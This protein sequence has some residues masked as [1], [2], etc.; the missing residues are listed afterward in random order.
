MGP[1]CRIELEDFSQIFVSY[2]FTSF[3]GQTIKTWK[4]KNGTILPK[5]L[6]AWILTPPALS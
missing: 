6:R 1:N 3:L 4:M 5:I 2:C